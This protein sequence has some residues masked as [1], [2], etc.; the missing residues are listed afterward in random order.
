M[1]LLLDGQSIP[2]ERAVGL[3]RLRLRVERWTDLLIGR[4]AKDFNVAE[5]AVEPDR[6]RDFADDLK[7]EERSFGTDYIWS[8]TLTA[9]H[10]AFPPVPPNTPTA[11]LNSRIAGSVLGCF[12]ARL[13]DSTGVLS[14]LW[15]LRLATAASDTQGMVDEL[16]W[17]EPLQSGI[18][19]GHRQPAGQRSWRRFG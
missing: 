9:L 3:N 19:T 18:S 14:S 5:I 13:F 12:P 1:S 2:A 6:A 16:L 4:L 10:A 17:T 11:E 7:H 8:L 15:Q